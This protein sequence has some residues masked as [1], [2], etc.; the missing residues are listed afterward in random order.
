MDM[1]MPS[2]VFVM[3]HYCDALATLVC[4]DDEKLGPEKME[5]I[6]AL[7][8][9]LLFYIRKKYPSELINSICKKRYEFILQA[10]TAK[11][12]R[13]IMDMKTNYPSY[14]FG[15]WETGLYHLGEEELILWSEFNPAC[16]MVS[17]AAERCISLAKK[18][19][20]GF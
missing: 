1:N 9:R 15:S 20:Q 6:L 4:K 16:K 17:H 3:Y 13:E 5:A 8:A 18:Y 14:N 19:L 2:S 12:L 10:K 11:E 7:N